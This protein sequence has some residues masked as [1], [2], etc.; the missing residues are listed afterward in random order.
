[1]REDISISTV[2]LTAMK[3]NKYAFSIIL[4]ILCIVLFTI[5]AVAKKDIAWAIASA[6]TIVALLGH[7]TLYKIEDEENR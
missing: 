1:M 7:I 3:M 4:D 6:M 2:T 5:D